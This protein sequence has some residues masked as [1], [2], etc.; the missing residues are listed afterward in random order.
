MGLLSSMTSAKYFSDLA[1]KKG[2]LRKMQRTADDAG[3]SKR[4]YIHPAS[5]L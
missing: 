1:A 3:I 5:N 4:N 2:L